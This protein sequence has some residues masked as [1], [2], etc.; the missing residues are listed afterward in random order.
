MT[1][2]V[3]S[4]LQTGLITFIVLISATPLWA[5]PDKH[6]DP[7]SWDRNIAGLM[8]KYCYNCH[9]DRKT[10]GG[11]NL[12]K[13]VNPRMILDNRKTWEEAKSM[14]EFDAM[15]P[16][17]SP[18]PTDE[19]RQLLVK[20]LDQTLES[21]DCKAVQD[22]GPPPFRRLNNVEYNNTVRDLTGLNLSPADNFSP[23]P[24]S[25]GFDN[26]GESLTLS[27]VLIEQYHKAAREISE[28]LLQNKGKEKPHPLLTIDSKTKGTPREQ[29]QQIISRFAT[30]AFRRPVESEYID[31]LMAIYDLSIKR[32]DEQTQAISH[33]FTAVLISPRFL[34]R[35]E[36]SKL[37]QSDPFPVDDYELATRLSYFL[38]SRPPDET[39]LKLASQGQLS[40]SR[41][42]E[43]QTR[44][45][46]ADPRCE[47]LV[48]NFFGQWLELRRVAAHQPDEISFPGY[49]PAL[50]NAITGEVRAL[51]SEIV[52][53]NRPIRELIDADYTY[54]NQALAEWYGIKGVDGDELRR[55]KL[56]DRRRGG[57][58]TTAAVLMLQSD[59]G[60]TNIPRRGNFIAG[61]ILGDA[62]PPPP[63]DVPELAEPDKNGKVL[64]LRER[65]ELHRKNAECAG[66]HARIDPIGFS[67]EN[68]DAVGRWRTKDAGL[69]IDTTGELPD[70]RKLA[71]PADL[72]DVLLQE[73]Q[74]FTKTLL[75]NLL[76]YALGRSL[77]AEDEC[78]IRDAIAATKDKESRFGELVVSI[79]QSYPFRHRRN[80]EY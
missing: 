14:I 37:D 2:R 63:P 48:D 43:E 8:K 5:Q 10:S 62:P 30:K 35:I 41:V 24:S 4:T 61:R 68:Y 29:A 39:L 16:D 38:W 9:N 7:L 17:K 54:V 13:D 56:E 15:P 67:L 32:G 21:L 76:I 52:Q 36:A 42:L 57:I 77:Q 26:I 55:V 3:F 50:Q 70:G 78:V 6:L 1:L 60:R 31:R 73:E 64:T 49:T 72:K 65:L 71:S 18:Q 27:P 45:M 79:V 74:A 19:E 23:D 34:I 25:F 59:P 75:Q 40:D 12:A 11:I 69:P 58:L 33:V 20:F 44:R 28:A 66:C 22:P 47:A 53:K 51:L 80:A 46:L